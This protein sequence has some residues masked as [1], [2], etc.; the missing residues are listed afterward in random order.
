MR[1]GY[2]DD[3]K[4][5][6]V[7]TRP[8]TPLP[9][10][11]YL[12]VDV[13]CALIS[14]TAGGYSFYK[15]AAHRRILRYRYNNVPSDRPGR[16][17]YIRDDKTGDYWSNSWQP[18]NKDLKK[19]KY[20]CAHGLSYTRIKSEYAGI[21]S[22]TL[23]FVPLGESLEIWK[24]KLTNKTKKK[25]K[26]S[27]FTYV[28]FCLWDA[29]NDMTDFQYNLNIGQT[30]FKNNAIYHLTL[31]HA[32]NK[33]FSY[34]WSN[35]KVVSYDGVRQNF[36]GPYRGEANPIAVEKG[37]CSN[38]LACGWAP[39]GGLHVRV[40]L[41][42]G[43]EKE[44]IFILGYAEK[45][46][47]ELKVFEKY[48]T[49]KNVE[50][51]LNELAEYWKENLNKY[52]VE[53]PDKQV[54]TMVNIWNQ[55]QCRTTFNWSRSASYY[56]AGGERGMGFRDSNQDTL[57]FVHQ[58][59]KKV[60]ERL[61]DLAS[62]QFPEGRAHH[63]YSPLTKK[64]S[65]EGFGDDHLWLVMAVS[66]YIKETGDINFLNEIVPYNDGSKG[67]MYEHLQRAIEYTWNNTGWHGLPKAGHADWN[68]CLNLH[69]PNGMGVS[70]MIAEMFV[71]CANLLSELAEKSGRVLEVD[72]YRDMAREMKD[73]INKE[74]WDGEWYVR[75][76]DDSGNVVGSKKNEEGKI[77]LE[78]QTWAVLSGVAEGERAIK[79]MDSVKKHLYTEYGILLFQP[80]FT[81]YNPALGYVTVFPPGLKENASIFCHTNPWAMIA[82]T[83]IG[84][85]DIAFKYYKTIL[86]AAIN[87]KADIHWTE[88]YVYSQMIAGRDHKDFGQAKNS[89]LTGTTAW[90][91][92]AISQYILGIRPT[93]DGLIVDPCIPSKWKGYK[94]KRVFRGITYN[95]S[96][97]NPKGVSK[98]VEKI[99]VDN[100]EIKGNII[101]L[102]KDKRE[103]FVEVIMG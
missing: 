20:E 68:D 4:K 48:S 74:A 83:M 76:F 42:P 49:T 40:N 100:K 47:E 33:F 45:L 66:S 11:N 102:F 39:F 96:V 81:K 14:N 12:G 41:N 95:I 9:W 32:H 98:G 88:P 79:C 72:K 21:L 8:D 29:H 75:A 27:L 59:P 85:G 44:V 84:R 17:I 99:L 1:F 13:Y 62:V 80:A 5:E 25:R 24:I 53:T 78:T 103:H 19:Y 2:F 90:N 50:A 64:G 54:N 52:T 61:I 69:G 92:V 43:K 10:I 101:P 67:K 18:T 73:R 91:F 36:V 46:G 63:G 94:V 58:I 37:R 34:F 60:K 55:Y 3:A 30:E 86:P 38:S 89:W 6:Y 23:Y 28:E 65:K 51:A 97:N 57:G 7:I 71:Y 31:Y 93:F 22:E 56:E 82:E 15:D 35:T 70:V 26:I 16:Y 87:D 77:W